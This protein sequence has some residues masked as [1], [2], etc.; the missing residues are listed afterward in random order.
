M[1]SLCNALTVLQF[2]PYKIKIQKL[3]ES[4][5]LRLKKS[6]M[7]LY[8]SRQKDFLI[9]SICD[10]RKHFRLGKLF[11]ENKGLAQSASTY[12]LLGTKMNRLLFC[13]SKI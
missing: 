10:K 5:T 8:S 9:N 2:R 4:G 13:M 12:L 7:R 11:N 6:G 1:T 3:P